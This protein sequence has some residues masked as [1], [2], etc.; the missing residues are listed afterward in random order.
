M[1]DSIYIIQAFK[2]GN[3]YIQNTTFRT[4]SLARFPASTHSVTSKNGIIPYS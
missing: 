4:F 2:K 3:S 1:S